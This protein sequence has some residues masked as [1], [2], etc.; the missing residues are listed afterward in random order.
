MRT[1]IIMSWETDSGAEWLKHE[2]EIDTSTDLHEIIE[3]WRDRTKPSADRLLNGWL[4]N[5]E[6]VVIYPVAYLSYEE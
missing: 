2:Q 6:D 3:E 5:G 4:V 1:K